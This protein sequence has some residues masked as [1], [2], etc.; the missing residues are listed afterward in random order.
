MAMNEVR[1]VLEAR[2]PGLYGRIEQ[3]LIDDE[4]RFCRRANQPASEFLV[5]HTRRT[6]AIA[7][8]IAQMEGIDPFLPVLAALFH[9]AGKFHEGAYH[10]DDIPEEEHAA[11]IAAFV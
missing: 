4:A 5:E 3:V 2:C 7:L 10:D 8:K 6:A 9:D 11:E 1:N